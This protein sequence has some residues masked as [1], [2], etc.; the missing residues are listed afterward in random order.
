VGRGRA[1]PPAACPLSTRGGTRFVRLVRGRGV[2]GREG[3]GTCWRSDWLRATILRSRDSPLRPRGA[4][5]RQGRARLQS[6]NR[7]RRRA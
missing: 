2:A 6:T 1:P 7:G 4:R 5:V 3:E